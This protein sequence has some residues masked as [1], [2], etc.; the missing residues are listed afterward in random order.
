MHKTIRQTA[1]IGASPKRVFEALIDEKKHRAFTGQ[2]AAISRKA[3]GAF[4]C[5]GGYLSGFNLEVVPS[6]R[7]VQAWRSKGWPAGFFS[8][9]TFA[10]S[11]SRGGATRLSFTQAGVP[12]ADVK[13][14]SEGWRTHYWKP[15]KAYLEK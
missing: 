3:G 9:V 15:L 1:T 13:A 6:K 4:T 2:P 7:I 11:R 8:I 10:L 12:A 14:K 5:Y